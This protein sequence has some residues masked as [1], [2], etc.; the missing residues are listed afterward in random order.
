MAKL[1]V[2]VVLLPSE[3]MMDQAIALNRRLPGC[4]D[5]GMILNKKDCLPHI[6]LAMGCIAGEA[7]PLIQ[8]ILGKIAQRFP[9]LDL[10]ATAVRAVTSPAGRTV[11]SIE[12]ER[13][14]GLQR[15]HEAVMSKL[16]PHFSYTVSPEMFFVFLADGVAD[17]TA[18]A[19]ADA[20]A[21]TT[22]DKAAISWVENFP[23]QSSFTRF[24]PH[25]TAGFGQ[26]DYRLGPM[27]F[28]PASLALCQLGNF[29]TC[30]RILAA[31]DLR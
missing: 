26:T 12:I 5:Q 21:N 15:L 2:D 17:E 10:T 19:T 18:D 25:I 23:A 31:A 8:T 11:S 4:S 9:K 30:R 6:S 22:I 1:A 16:S 13:T 14:A 24:S 3:A 27:R 7:V 28:R 29:C 20:T